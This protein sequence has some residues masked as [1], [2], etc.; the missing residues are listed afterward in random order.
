LR[1]G[2]E[3]AFTRADGTS[4]RF[5]VERTEQ[6]DRQRFPIDAVYYPTLT[7][8]RGSG[9][10]QVAPVHN[11]PVGVQGTVEP[12]RLTGPDLLGDSELLEHLADRE[13]A[14]GRVVQDPVV[15]GKSPSQPDGA[16]EHRVGP[17]NGRL[18]RRCGDRC[19]GASEVPVHGVGSRRPR[20]IVGWPVVGPGHRADSHTTDQ[21]DHD[22]QAGKEQPVKRRPPAHGPSGGLATQAPALDPDLG[23]RFPLAVEPDHVPSQ[24]LELPMAVVFLL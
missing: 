19:R 16:G 5:A 9:D 24:R 12:D 18:A 8:L 4:V 20:R 23:G 13:P 21:R 3:I 2:D 7:L 11:L 10:A 17:V 6:H 14:V 22:Q 15:L 1:R